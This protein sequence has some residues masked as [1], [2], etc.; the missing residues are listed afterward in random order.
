M[1]H[2]HAVTAGSMP[3]AP[4]AWKLHQVP[5][6]RETERKETLMKQSHAWL[7]GISCVCAIA[8]AQTPDMHSPA[9]QP[10]A[11]TGNAPGAP[12]M[13]SSGSSMP[14]P[15]PMSRLEPQTANGVT[16]LCGGV[17]AGEVA[18]MK[19]RAR[20]YDMML[21]FAT[22][23]GE[24]LADVNVDIK[25]AK[26]NSL[27]QARCDGPIMLVDF[28]RGGTYRVHAETGGYSLDRT[29]RIAARQDRTTSFVMHW[30]Q[31]IGQEPAASTG[32]SGNAGDSS[33]NSDNGVNGDS[34]TGGPANPTGPSQ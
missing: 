34:A 27:V 23:R 19:R 30:P 21:T 31:Q 1:V 13:E 6:R 11:P 18:L 14:P 3:A 33:D 2:F 20:D 22:K 24:Y 12:G 28:T 29:A 10:L 15:A 17:G 5:D 7:A 4:S 26:G 9:D 32:S 25:D 16:W 8:S